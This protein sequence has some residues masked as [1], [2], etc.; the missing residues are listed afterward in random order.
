MSVEV[1]RSPQSNIRQYTKVTAEEFFESY[2]N[3]I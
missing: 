2:L 1:A 3:L